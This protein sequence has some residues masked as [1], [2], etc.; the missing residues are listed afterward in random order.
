[1][2]VVVDEDCNETFDS[3]PMVFLRFCVDM[4]VVLVLPI[5]VLLCCLQQRW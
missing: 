3:L 2:V 4:V 5:G 1:V